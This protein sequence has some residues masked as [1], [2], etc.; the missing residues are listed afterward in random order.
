MI[1]RFVSNKLDGMWM[2][3]VMAELG[4]YNDIRISL[5]REKN[6]KKPQSL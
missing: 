3:A 4:Y 6:H 2:G 5:E 1:E